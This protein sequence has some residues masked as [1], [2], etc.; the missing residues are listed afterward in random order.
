MVVT[1]TEAGSSYTDAQFRSLY[2]S[3]TSS[4]NRVQ[5]NEHANTATRDV[6]TNDLNALFTVPSG[7]TAGRFIYFFIPRYYFENSNGT[8]QDITG[9]ANPNIE[10]IFDYNGTNQSYVIDDFGELDADYWLY[11]SNIQI[12]TQFGNSSNRTPHIVIRLKTALGGTG[13]IGKI[14]Q[15]KNTE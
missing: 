7:A 15:L 4:S 1:T 6:S 11:G 10:F 3:Q 14:Y 12:E 9:T 5:R 2:T 8:V 13:Q